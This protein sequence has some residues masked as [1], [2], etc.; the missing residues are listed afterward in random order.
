MATDQDFDLLTVGETADILKVSRVTIHRW[1]KQGR[2][3][4]YHVG[5][6]AVRI[7]RGDL[8]VV[9]TPLHGREDEHTAPAVGVQAT[10]MQTMIRPL[11]EEEK[12]RGLEALEASRRLGESVLARLGGKVFEET[13]PIIREAREERSRRAL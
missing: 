13:W 9:V 8:A 4:A 1:L 2:L 3:P 11:T 5:P 12:R 6:K 7:R 10:P